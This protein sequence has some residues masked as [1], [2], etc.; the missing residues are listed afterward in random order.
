MDLP[1][2]ID[3]IEIEH[4]VVLSMVFASSCPQL[5]YIAHHCTEGISVHAKF[6]LP[7]FTDVCDLVQDRLAWIL[8][9]LY[10]GGALLEINLYRLS[11]G[12]YFVHPPVLAL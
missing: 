3:L 10:G 7:Q 9:L 12:L 5:V 4:E 6:E 8:K 11:H 1:V 2:T